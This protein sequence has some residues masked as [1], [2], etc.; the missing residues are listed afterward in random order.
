MPYITP[1]D[2]HNIHDFDT[3]L[4]FLREK[5]GWHIPENVELEDIAFPWSPEDLDLDELTEE[6]IPDCQQLPPFPTNQLEFEF[7]DSTQPWGIFFLQFDS[8]LVYRTALRRVLRGLVE[9]RD[10]DASLPAWKYDQLLFICTTTDFQ[11][12]AF[13]HFAATT[14]NWRRAVLSI[15]SWEQGDTH[16]RTLCEYNLP[17]LTFPNSGFPTDQKWLSEWQKAFD[18]EAVTDKFFADYQRV[19]AQ[20]EDAIEGIPE[21]ETEKRRLYTQRLFNR[22]MFLR[23]IEKKGWLTYKGDRNYLRALFNA[24]DNTPLIR[25]DEG[26]LDPSENFLNDCLYWAFFNGLGAPG[27]SPNDRPE[28]VERRGEVPFLNGGLFEMQEYDSRNAVHIPNDKFAE[29]LKLFERYNFTVTESTLLDIEVAVDPEMLGQV[30]EELVTEREEIGSY[31]TPRPVVS[32]M[33]RESLKICLQNKTD[34]T[35]E[36][37]KKFV[38]DGDATA[39]R[40]PE[41]VLRVLQTLRICDPACGSG[42]YLLGMMGELLRLREALFKS[43]QVDS[44]T[45]YQRK[46]DI[47]Q[48]NLYGVDKD[49]FAVNI[50]MLRLWLSLAVDYEDEVPE[51]LPNLDYKVATGDSL[52]GPAP[53]PP[54]EQFSLEEQLIQQIQERHAEYLVTHTD[55]EKRELRETIAELKGQLHGWQANEDVFVWQVEFPEVFQEGGFD[56]VIGNPPYLNHKREYV[57]TLKPTFKV[58]FPE[59]YTGTA[60]VYVYFYKRG[61][62]LL[63]LSG[64]LTYISSNTFLRVKFGKKLRKFLTDKT[65]LHK[66]LDFAS[67]PVF[68]NASVDPCIVLVESAEPNGRNL[69]AATFRDKADIP[70]ISQTFQKLAF[71]MSAQDLSIDGWTLASSK[72][73]RLLEKLG[74]IGTPLGD[75]FHRGLTTG[76]NKVFVV[77]ADTYKDLIDADAG[78]AELIKPSLRGDTLKNGKWK[79]KLPKEYIIVIASSKNKSWPWSNAENDSQAED[80]F[81]KT[82]PAI[83][84]RLSCYRDRLIDRDDRGKFYWEL[85]SCTYYDEFDKPKI[86]YP[87]IAKSFYV[88]YDTAKMF[89]VNTIYF[90]PTNDLSL[91]S[92]LGSRLFDWYAR[93]KFHKLQDPWAGGSLQ[94]NKVNMETVPIAERTATQKAELSSLVEQILV[95]PQSDQVREIERKIDEL[96]YQLYNLTDAEIELIKQTYRDA[97]ME[98]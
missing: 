27:G 21:G 20:V 78:S 96:V 68:K 98:A 31:Y 46:L 25:G 67:V 6:R 44:K 57:K 10:R 62:E 41:K 76:L 39:I 34:E 29:I 26:G 65:C 37:L 87:R 58:L 43:R 97:G 47:I 70:R 83:Y 40:D 71:Q 74:D 11:R 9:R 66:L 72:V 55:S 16:I 59:V 12:F 35:Q 56:M 81:A 94:F 60:D 82:Y 91:L 15:F 89:G 49:E 14:E 93:H 18:V 3:L 36:C 52:T 53:E 19:F 51:P 22:L 13:A 42:A 64:I 63:R 75:S 32:F 80:I 77:D 92:I 69:L 79:L 84:Q 90:L 33:C 88:Y 38:D 48:K 30:F 7:S 45:T 95:D 85:R 73:L 50:A 54:D 4:D 2:I 61:V 1:N 8:E 23:F 86:I 28:I 5:L 24:V 17:A